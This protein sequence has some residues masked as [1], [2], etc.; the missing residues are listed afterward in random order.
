MLAFFLSFLSFTL[1]LEDIDNLSR[2]V[3]LVLLLL[4]GSVE[5]FY[6]KLRIDIVYN[7]IVSNTYKA[8]SSTSAFLTLS[9]LV[10]ETLL[11]FLSYISLL[12]LNTLALDSASYILKYSVIDIDNFN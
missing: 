8:F 9:F 3:I 6:V 4:L 7:S 12:L 5:N 1:I 2:V 10:I 11:I